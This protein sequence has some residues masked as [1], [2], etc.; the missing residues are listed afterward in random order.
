MY[1]SL[2]KSLNI[3]FFCFILLSLYCTIGLQTQIMY[4]QFMGKYVLKIILLNI[5]TCMIKVRLY[6]SAVHKS[7]YT[8]LSHD[9]LVNV[10]YSFQAQ[11][12][13]LASPNALLFLL[14]PWYFLFSFLNFT[15]IIFRFEFKLLLTVVL[16]LTISYKGFLIIPSIVL[17]QYGHWFDESEEKM[18]TMNK[19]TKYFLYTSAHQISK[20]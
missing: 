5:R 18:H 4:Y 3:S 15:C 17:I 20:V 6:N 19:D 12:C 2:L 13:Q 8:S 9:I 10:T 14:Q 11:L 16:L 7:W 1:L